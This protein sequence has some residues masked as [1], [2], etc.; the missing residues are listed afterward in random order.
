MSAQSELRVAVDDLEKLLHAA[1]PLPDEDVTDFRK[2][3]VRV[4]RQVAEQIALLSSMGA[5]SRDRPGQ[6]EYRHQIS[7]LRSAVAHHQ[8]SWP[9]VSIDTTSLAYQRSVE[10]MRV[11]ARRFIE[12]ARTGAK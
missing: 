6:D 4:R 9:A 1:Q 11:A 10:P 12:W 2:R 3:L 8:A 5:A 7:T